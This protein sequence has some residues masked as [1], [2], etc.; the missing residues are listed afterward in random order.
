MEYLRNLQLLRLNPILA[1]SGKSQAAQLSKQ[2]REAV[3]SRWWSDS[4][5]PR[6]MSIL[7]QL[8]GKV[9]QLS[10]QPQEVV[11]SRW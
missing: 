9:A 7:Q 5:Q 2:R 11:T 1:T 6:L 3:T 8:G 10:K 4:S